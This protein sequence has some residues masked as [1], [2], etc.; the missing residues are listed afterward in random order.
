[1][2]YGV[3]C[4]PVPLPDGATSTRFSPHGCAWFGAGMIATLDLDPDRCKAVEIRDDAMAP[5]LPARSIALIDERVTERREGAVYALDSPG[6]IVMRRAMRDGRR[7]LAKPDCPGWEPTF[8]PDSGADAIIG[9]AVWRAR[10]VPAGL[11]SEPV[12]AAPGEHAYRVVDVDTADATPVAVPWRGRLEPDDPRK[13]W[14]QI[15]AW[16][17]SAWLEKNEI[18]PL[19]AEVVVPTD[20]TMSP[21]LWPN[22]PVLVDRRRTALH[23]GAIYELET[24]DGLAFRRVMKDGRNWE[25]RADDPQIA[26]RPWAR[27]DDAVGQVVWNGGFMP[28]VGAEAAHAM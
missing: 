26:P 21:S 23:D 18:E 16:F 5:A 8:W 4:T 15:G 7:W 19:E 14:M 13:F 25:V 17:G 28:G 22:S 2:N 9:E 11:P 6:G 20:N 10:M 3:F 1:M 12:H 24:K 27:T